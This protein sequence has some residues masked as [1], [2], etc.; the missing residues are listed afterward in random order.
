LV[1]VK[2][3]KEKIFFLKKVFKGDICKNIDKNRKNLNKNGKLATIMEKG[4]F[5][6]F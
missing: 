3:L 4:F 2:Y 6:S 1:A 5:L